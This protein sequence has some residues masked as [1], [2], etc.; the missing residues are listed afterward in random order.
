MKRDRQTGALRLVWRSCFIFGLVATASA[1]TYSSNPTKTGRSFSV[2][3]V[4]EGKP[5]AGVRVELSTDPKG[6]EASRSLLTIAT[7][8]A[9]QSKFH[10]VKPGRYYVG[11]SDAAFPQSTEI[12]VDGRRSKAQTEK[13][14]FEWP[15]VNPLAVRFI[16]GLLNAALR[17]GEPL[18]DQAHP[19]FGALGGARLTLSRAVSGEVIETQTASESGSFGFQTV[20][21]GLY[22]LKV[23]VQTSERYRDVRGYVPI[24]VDP[25]A[26]TLDLNLFLQPGVC[27]AL[28]FEN[29]KESAI[30]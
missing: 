4:N 24:E 27:G 7:D 10:D 23:E 19:T 28:A 14:T 15:G 9:G 22:M 20:A 3:V 5:L 16:S 12:V 26:K 6:Y 30:Q 21:A 2:L 11:I 25:D 8:D 18:K 13:I 1:C 29:R 17:T